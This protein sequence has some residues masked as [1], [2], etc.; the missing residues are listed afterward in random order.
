MSQNN[1]STEIINA[2]TNYLIFSHYIDMKF[3]T[4]M[5][6]NLPSYKMNAKLILL[7]WVCGEHAG[8]IVA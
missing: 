4:L 7:C 2:L 1:S 6:K 3:E 5:F 8:L